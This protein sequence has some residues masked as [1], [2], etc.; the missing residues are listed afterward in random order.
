MNS[1]MIPQTTE[2]FTKH[3]RNT[4]SPRKWHIPRSI[5]PADVNRNAPRRKGGKFWSAPPM[6]K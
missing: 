6:K 3:L 1:N 4:C 5:N 2:R